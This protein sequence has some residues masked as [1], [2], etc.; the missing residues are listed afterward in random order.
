MKVHFVRVE[1]TKKVAE[2][3]VT[4]G[5]HVYEGD[6]GLDRANEIAAIHNRHYPQN[7]WFVESVDA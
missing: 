3:N 2:G 7:K 4:F 5:A 6:D 1:A